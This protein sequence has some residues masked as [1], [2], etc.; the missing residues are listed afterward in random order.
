M[1]ACASLLAVPAFA[2]PPI[3]RM[4]WERTGYGAQ[5]NVTQSTPFQH[6]DTYPVPDGSGAI[7]SGSAFAYPGHVGV[8]NRLEH[9]WSGGPASSS[10]YKVLSYASTG[11]FVISGPGEWV[12]GQLHFRARASL[13]RSGTGQSTRL[14]VDARARNGALIAM[15]DLIWN[16]SGT[17]GTGLL[18]G[19]TNPDLDFPFVLSGF[20][21]VGTP[22]DVL[23]AIFGLENTSASSPAAWARADAG[24]NSGYGLFLEEASGQ[25][26]TLPTGYT[27]NSPNWGVVDNHFQSIVGVG[28]APGSEALRLSAHPNPFAGTSTVSFVQPQ[29]AHVRLQVFDLGGR[30]VR[31]LA[32]EWHAVGT[33]RFQWDGLDDDGS[34]VRAGLYFARVEADGRTASQRIVRMR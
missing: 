18:A 6:A 4:T 30:L 34:V 10:V 32:D 14:N 31:T 26:L 16:N 9:L 8:D 15:G 19:L 22:F 21:P 25:I 28:P 3:Y 27:L 1:M 33:Q 5:Y 23:M 24:T 2:A 17:N 20:F 13:S 12:E 11:D 29:A 7:F